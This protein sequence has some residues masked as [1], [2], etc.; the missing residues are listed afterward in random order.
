MSGGKR[1]EGCCEVLRLVL[2]EAAEF[3]AREE[4]EVEVSEEF[5][6]G[7]WDRV[8]CKLCEF[9]RGVTTK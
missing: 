7:S 9:V 1:D 3:V 8:D 5:D 6:K 4:D 2:E